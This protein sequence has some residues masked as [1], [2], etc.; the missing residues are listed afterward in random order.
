MYLLNPEVEAVF[1]DYP[2]E[3]SVTLGADLPIGVVLGPPASSLSFLFMLWAATSL[4]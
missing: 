3:P 4:P 1:S 2:G